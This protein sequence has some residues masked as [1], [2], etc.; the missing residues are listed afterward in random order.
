MRQGLYGTA[1]GRGWGR[2]AFVSI[3]DYLKHLYYH[4]AHS[5]F[6]NQGGQEGIIT[7]L[8]Q[9]F[10]SKRIFPSLDSIVKIKNNVS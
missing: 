6:F 10:F 1:P 9:M 4:I 8:F 3:L 2:E 5:I 7:I